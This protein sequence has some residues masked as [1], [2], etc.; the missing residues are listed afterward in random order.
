VLSGEASAPCAKISGGDGVGGEGDS[1][2]RFL[3]DTSSRVAKGE[4]ALQ[5]VAEGHRRSLLNITDNL[6]RNAV[7]W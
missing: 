4:G 1:R 3:L 5:A 2:S 6:K 7:R